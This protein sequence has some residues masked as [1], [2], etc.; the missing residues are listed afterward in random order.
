MNKQTKLNKDGSVKSRGIEWTQYTWN[1][2]AGCKHRCRWEMPDGN[3]AICYAEAVAHGVAQSAYAEGFEHHYWNP[4]QL[5]APRK[6]K[7]PARIFSDSMSD[8]MGAWVPADHIQQVIDV[9]RD[10]PQHTYQILTKNAPRYLKFDW[11]INAWLGVSTPPN[12]MFGHKMDGDRR[13]AYLRVASRVLTALK[14]KGNTVWVS[15]E[16][17]TINLD[18]CIRSGLMTPD[19]VVIGA[20]S[21][22]RQEFAPDVKLVVPLVEICDRYS[23]PVFY[24]G[25]MRS[26]PYAARDWREAFPA[27]KPVAP[28]TPLV[29]AVLL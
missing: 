11:P 8:L 28:A 18:S 2:I 12:W 14:S 9:M 4:H 20:A 25:N 16:P 5:D 10:T 22:G 21:N 1:P 27:T 7:T 26:L 17:L 13:A 24:K 29:Q 15:A 23:I 19:W 6:L 3:T